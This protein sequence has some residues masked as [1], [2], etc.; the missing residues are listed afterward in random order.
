MCKFC[1]L[2]LIS[3]KIAMKWKN[4]ELK[5]GRISRRGT[6]FDYKTFVFFINHYL[7]DERFDLFDLI[8]T[9]S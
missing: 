3:I 7:G 5:G 1:F 9:D 6:L 8:F 2:G 4:N